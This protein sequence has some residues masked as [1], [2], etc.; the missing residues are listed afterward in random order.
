MFF[1]V[2][3]SKGYCQK[4]GNKKKVK[5]RTTPA[6]INKK[7]PCKSM[8]W[9]KSFTPFNLNYHCLDCHHLSSPSILL[10][11]PILSS[12][13]S[14]ELWKCT[15]QFES[16]T[17]WYLNTITQ[18]GY[19]LAWQHLI[20]TTTLMIYPKKICIMLPC[21]HIVVV[22]KFFVF[23]WFLSKCSLILKIHNRQHQLLIVVS[24]HM[25]KLNIEK[26]TNRKSK[27]KKKNHKVQIQQAWKCN[28]EDRNSRTRST[29][30]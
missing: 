4:W 11:L 14:Q 23:G 25:Y 16:S 3:F 20:S 30:K 7:W 28:Q 1:E 22:C 24:L 10:P 13:S 5:L 15:L 9:S 17:L 27:E 26:P 12:P 8:L 2:C 6:I 21:S 18:D 29:M 19:L